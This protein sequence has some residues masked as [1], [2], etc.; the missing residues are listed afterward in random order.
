MKRGSRVV[1]TGGECFIG[2][3]LAVTDDMLIIEVAPGV[4]TTL[5][6]DCASTQPLRWQCAGMPVEVQAYTDIADF[7]AKLFSLER[8][9]RHPKT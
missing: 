1:V 3:V 7:R 6:R 8:K 5:F 9:T 4:T 2:T